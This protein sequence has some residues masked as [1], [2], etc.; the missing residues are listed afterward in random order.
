MTKLTILPKKKR[1]EYLNIEDILHM[2]DLK[3]VIQDIIT[4]SSLGQ[5]FGPSGIGKSFVTL[6]MALCVATGAKWLGTHD[7]FQGPVIYVAAEGS[8]G[9][10]KRIISWL[11]HHNLHQDCLLEN[12]RLIGEALPLSEPGDVRQLIN[13]D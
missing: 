8:R 1:F 4:E 6:D 10:K 2:P 7:V 11:D 12:F 13:Q 9:Y 3:W 5:L